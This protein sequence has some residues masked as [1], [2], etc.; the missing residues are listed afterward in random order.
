MGTYALY[1]SKLYWETAFINGK[2]NIVCV[3]KNIIDR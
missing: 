3:L 2:F 1:I